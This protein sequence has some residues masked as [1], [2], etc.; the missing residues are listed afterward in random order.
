M[1]T[2]DAM[3]RLAEQWETMAENL[4]DA[5][6]VPR[7][8]NVLDVLRGCAAELRSTL[9]AGRPGVQSTG[10]GPAPA[11][12]GGGG[13][14]TGANGTAETLRDAAAT[15]RVRGAATVH[16][17]LAEPLAALLEV[18]AD[19]ADDYGDLPEFV[20]FDSTQAPA[21]RFTFRLIHDGLAVARGILGSTD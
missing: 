7:H 21:Y 16:S 19:A 10:S 15:L 18:A 20:M 4:S 1:S 14:S 5:V 12:P 17:A 13:M 2:Q 9:E 3:V 11:R 8:P 6:S